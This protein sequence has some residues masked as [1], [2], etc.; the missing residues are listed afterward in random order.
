MQGYVCQNPACLKAVHNNFGRFM[1]D[2]ITEKCPRCG[3]EE[4]VKVSKTRFNF[5]NSYNCFECGQR[6]D[7]KDAVANPF[8]LFCGSSDVCW[9][10]QKYKSPGEIDKTLRMIADRH[11]LTDMGQRG[12]TRAGETAIKSKIQPTIEKYQNVAC[13]VAGGVNVPVTNDITSTWSPMAA[14]MKIDN[15]P[16]V[17]KAISSSRSV[18]AEFTDMVAI[19][20]GEAA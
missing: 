8:C 17:G 16:K 6:S 10:P 5:G 19:H 2:N 9:L 11:G 15:A 7:F 1:G 18:P 13:G 4:I 14:P 3:C 12:G 20:K